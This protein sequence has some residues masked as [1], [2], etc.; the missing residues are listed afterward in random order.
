MVPTP[1]LD[2]SSMGDGT[3]GDQLPVVLIQTASGVQPIRAVVDQKDSGLMSVITTK[4]WNGHSKGYNLTNLDLAGLTPA[5][6][7]RL[8]DQGVLKDNPIMLDSITVPDSIGKDGTRITGAVYVR[9]PGTRKWAIGNLPI[10]GVSGADIP[11][12]TNLVGVDDKG[13]YQLQYAPRAS[14]LEFD[15]PKAGNVTGAQADAWYNSPAADPYRTNMW[16]DDTGAVTDLPE[17]AD[18]DGRK[19]SPPT[20]AEQGTADVIKTARLYQEQRREQAITAAEK[21]KAAVEAARNKASGAIYHDD[22]AYDPSSPDFV[23]SQ[24]DTGIFP[25]GP[26][27]R[28]MDEIIKGFGVTSAKPVNKPVNIHSASPKSAEKLATP[29]PSRGMLPENKKDPNSVHVGREVLEPTRLPPRRAPVT[30]TQ[31]KPSSTNRTQP[32]VQTKAPAPSPS[33]YGP[34]PGKSFKPP[35]PPQHK[36]PTSAAKATNYGPRAV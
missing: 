25:I 9:D 13:E 7:Q 33:R 31:R 27:M 14:V 12:V 34:N 28:Q 24:P 2:T 16:R 18:N 36:P 30:T 23:D 17:F 8:V 3:V 29:Q 6:H 21:V 11:G 32:P 5:E 19:Y 1:V 35:S 15:V 26:A 10:E 4:D 20:W 22:P